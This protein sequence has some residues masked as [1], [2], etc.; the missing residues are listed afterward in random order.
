MV[1]VEERGGPGYSAKANAGTQG[2]EEK[3]RLL[4]WGRAAY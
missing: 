3:W 1:G 4:S 2:G